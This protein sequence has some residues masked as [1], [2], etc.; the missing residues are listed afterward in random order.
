MTRAPGAKPRR[1]QLVEVLRRAWPDEVGKQ[2]KVL[3]EAASRDAPR[4]QKGRTRL[5]MVVG[6]GAGQTAATV[7]KKVAEACALTPR[8]AAKG[9]AAGSFIAVSRDAQKNLLLWLRVRPCA[10]HKL[11]SAVW[12]ELDAAEGSDLKTM[13]DTILHLHATTDP[14]RYT[15]LLLAHGAIKEKPAAPAR[16]GSSCASRRG[17][18]A[19]ERRTLGRAPSC[20]RRTADR[21]SAASTSSTRRRRRPSSGRCASASRCTARRAT[22][23]ACSARG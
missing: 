19:T 11:A 22:R 1:D 18:S 8:A 7:G 13:Q 20:A 4:P 16:R 21:R 17:G 6:V 3:R 9:L 12:L 2:L 5:M 15:V 23:G 14:T 10:H